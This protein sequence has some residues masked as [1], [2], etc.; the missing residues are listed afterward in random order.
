MGVG[1][2][3]ALHCI[4]ALARHDWSLK[5]TGME[6]QGLDGARILVYTDNG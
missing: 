3:K 4:M 5:R 1:I 2:G 6:A